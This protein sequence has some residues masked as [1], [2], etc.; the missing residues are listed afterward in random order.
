MTAIREWPPGRK[1]KIDADT[2]PVV[3]GLGSAASG[4]GI[5]AAKANGDRANFEGLLRGMELLG[6]PTW[7]WRGDKSYFFGY[8]LLGDELA[9]WG[10]TLRPWAV[11][12]QT[13]S[14]VPP[15]QKPFVP[16][17]GGLAILVTA[18]LLLAGRETVRAV[19]AC[20]ASPRRWGKT[21][22]IFLGISLAAV[23][24]WLIIPAVYWG[25]IFVLMGVLGAVERRRFF[26]RQ[27]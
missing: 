14:W 11:G 12:F 27:E 17:V 23:M 16:V 9:L 21:Q 15:V 26:G 2:G 5:A 20:H 8:L 18:L 13:S 3:Y 24:A 6:A 22:R 7:N 25:Y 1:G 10:R 19:T 4:L